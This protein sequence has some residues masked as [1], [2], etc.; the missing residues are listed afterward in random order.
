AYEDLAT[1]EAD[2]RRGLELSPNS[3]KGHHGLA[4]V[5][6]ETP[7]R[8]DEALA[9]LDRARK[10]DPLRPAYDVTRAV[11]L[12]Y[13]RADVRGAD[14][15]LAD[16]LRRHPDYQPALARLSEV[17]GFCMGR[18]ADAIEYAERA[19]SLDPLAEEVRRGLLRFYLA[20]GD[21]AAAEDV[22]SSAPHESIVRRIPVLVHQRDWVAAGDAAYEGLALQTFGPK[23]IALGVIAIRMHARTTRDFERARH[24]LQAASHVQWDVTGSPLL[25]DRPGLREEAIGLADVLV[26]MGR[27]LEGRRLL[28]VILERMRREID[29][30][31][32]EYW[33]RITHSLALAVNDD[34]EAALAMLQRAVSSRYAL[35]DWWYYF[36]VEPAFASL[37]KDPRFTAMLETARANS[38]EQRRELDRRRKDGRVPARGAA[39]P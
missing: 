11:F 35:N 32:S 28:A 22:V 17:R 23:D 20:V 10:L 8:R 26:A 13:E 2:Y 19:L 29:G 4:V 21:V 34:P 37:H 9:M 3:A 24:A 12:L 25:P 15:L 1:A 30:G 5:L 39:G 31:R 36:E 6:Y 7:S 14:D 33:Y 38:V 27:G 18:S 16:V